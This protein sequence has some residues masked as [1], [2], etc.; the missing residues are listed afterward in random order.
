MSKG[1]LIAALCCLVMLTMGSPLAWCDDEGDK[2]TQ[3]KQLNK[4]ISNL[5][6]RLKSFR[7]QRSD[8][9][10]NLRSAEIK[11]SQHQQTIQHT[12]QQLKKRKTELKTLQDQRKTLQTDRLEQQKMISS[13]VLAAFQIGQ[14]KKLK[15]LL[16]QEDP[17]KLSR[18][19]TYYDYFNRARSEQI[20]RYINIISELDTLEPQIEAKTTELKLTTER[21]TQSH[22][23]LLSTQQERQRS[24]AKINSTIKNK[25]QRLKSINKD[26]IEL[27]RLIKAVEQAITNI[28]LPNQYR[29]FSQFKGK[30]SWPVNGKPNNRFGKPRSG[31]HIRWQ[32]VTIPVIQ[33]S[34]VSAIHHG[35]V[36]FADWLRG[37]GLLLIIDHGDGYMSLYAHNQSLLAETGDWVTT[38]EKIA[39][40]GNTGGQNQS[41]LYFEI[42]HNGKPVN[43]RQ[44]CKRG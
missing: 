24:L 37:S 26:R 22:T 35:R 23:K 10:N 19:L 41:Q 8:L 15:V 5:R 42:R 13:Q 38:S 6:K 9:Q 44:W 18:A 17:E 32:G 21:L 7:N 29:P 4:E 40:A 36:V 34:A 27:E 43:P 3:L 2:R 30:L 20:H 31:S 12:Q 28:S 16:N 11:I 14:Q 39:T 25:D 33:G 1:R